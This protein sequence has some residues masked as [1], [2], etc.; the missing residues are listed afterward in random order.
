MLLAIVVIVPFLLMLIGIV[1]I[2][3]KDAVK[4]KRARNLLLGGVLLLLVEILIGYS[5][6]SNIRIGGMH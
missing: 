6:C 2:F 5:I 4:R 1:E 3:S